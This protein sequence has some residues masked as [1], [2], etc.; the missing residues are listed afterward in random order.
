MQ[1]LP[2]TSELKPGFFMESDQDKPV[3]YLYDAIGAHFGIDARQFTEMI[4][5]FGNRD[6][7]VRINSPGGSAFD[8]V[9]MMNTLKAHQ[10]HVT[11]IVDGYAASA[12]SLV[13][14]GGTEIL[15]NTGSQMMI[16]RASSVVLG[17]CNDMKEACNVLTGLDQEIARIYAQKTGTSTEVMLE[18]MDVETWMN[19][20]KAIQMG[21]ATGK[22]KEEA[23]TLLW[24]LEGLYKNLPSKAEEG[25]EL[26]RLAQHEHRLRLDAVR[27]MRCLSN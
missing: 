27:R 10:G 8:G 20:E 21:F 22:V 26:E 3:V 7:T 6:I 1:P 11:V 14:L 13:A 24:N 23:P 16:H 2:Q 25:S 19:D 12:A 15:M 5:Q 17:N 4:N 18:L 9:T